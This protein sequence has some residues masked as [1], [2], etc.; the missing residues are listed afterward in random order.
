ME[1]Y[2][3][4]K[5]QTKRFITEIYEERKKNHH[6]L[7]GHCGH[8]VHNLEL[9]CTEL[10]ERRSL[11]IHL[12]K[13]NVKPIQ[14]TRKTLKIQF[15]KSDGIIARWLKL[16]SIK[17]LVLPDDKGPALARE[18]RHLEQ[19]SSNCSQKIASTAHAASEGGMQK[20]YLS[21]SWHVQQHSFHSIHTHRITQSNLK[22]HDYDDLAEAKKSLNK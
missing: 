11:R 5:I 20:S 17:E 16:T 18:W 22:N 3:I 7:D 10:E 21:P 2:L 19:I 4:N 9:I 6:I 14:Y 13:E 12:E 15:I 8:Q 1:F